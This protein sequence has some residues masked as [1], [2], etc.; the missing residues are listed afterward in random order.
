MEKACLDEAGRQFTQAQ[1]T[2][3]LTS[4]LLNIFGETG[5]KK[6]ITQVLEGTFQPPPN[7][8]CYA[9]QFLSAVLRPSSVVDVPPRSLESYSRGWKKAQESMSSSTSGIHFGHYIT[10]TFNPE[11]LIINATLANIP[12][13]TGFTYDCW[14][15][16]LNI[17]I[18]KT[19]GDFNVE[20]L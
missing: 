12:L 9:A 18:E 5:T 3:F 15:K 6:S 1:H 2:P 13:L 10:S 16:G 8:D 11:T 4:P 17:M 7:C 19:A 20:K 14:K